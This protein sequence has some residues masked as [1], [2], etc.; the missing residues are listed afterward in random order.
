M[1]QGSIPE[2][3]MATSPSPPLGMEPQF[4]GLNDT[5]LYSFKEDDDAHSQLLLL[6]KPC[7]CFYAQEYLGTP[8]LS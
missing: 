8:H 1:L 7:A 2:D 4:P 6:L 5:Y 3:I